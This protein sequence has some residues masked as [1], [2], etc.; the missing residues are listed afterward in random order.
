MSASGGGTATR[1]TRRLVSQANV[2]A[3]ALLT[4][5]GA[6]I[7]L[8]FQIWPALSPDPRDRVGADVSIF[9]IEP[10]V[11]ISAWINRGFVP[12]ERPK[13]H[14][15]YPDDTT[16]GSLLYVRTT[17]DGHKHRHVTLS[18]RVYDAGSKRVLPPD[19]VDGPAPEALKLDSPSERSVTLFWIPSLKGRRSFVRVQ[20][21]DDKEMLAVADT[22]EIVNDKFA[23]QAGPTG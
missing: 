14:Q 15:R 1:R 3:V 18:Y 8:L 6:V 22:P 5:T 21:W 11:S 19:L 2:V 16:L 7:A 9:A 12:S 17:V 10:H 13:L 23:G 4:L 20:L